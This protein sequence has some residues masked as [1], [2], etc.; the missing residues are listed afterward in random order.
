MYN[1]VPLWKDLKI[2]SRFDKKNYITLILFSQ[3]LKYTKVESSISFVVKIHNTYFKKIEKPKIFEQYWR[4]KKAL[5]FGQMALET[6][7]NALV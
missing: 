6:F 1:N 5:Y 3:P 4:L 2:K 7:S